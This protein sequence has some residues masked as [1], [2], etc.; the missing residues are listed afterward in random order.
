MYKYIYIYIYIYGNLI[1]YEY[2]NNLNRDGD[3]AGIRDVK[4]ICTYGYS[5]TK[6]A[7]GRKWILQIDTCK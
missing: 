3:R 7:T 2:F 1:D 5:R 4:K 6:L